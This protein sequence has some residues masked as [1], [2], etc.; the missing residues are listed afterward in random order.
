M[1]ALGI[2]IYGVVVTLF[3]GFALGLLAWGILNEWQDEAIEEVGSDE[4]APEPA[5]TVGGASR[6][7]S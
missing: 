7:E 3:V 1:S 6:G 4:S 2:F 5:A